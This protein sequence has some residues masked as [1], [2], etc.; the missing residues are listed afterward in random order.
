MDEVKGETTKRHFLVVAAS[1]RGAR[2]F[3]KKALQQGHAVTAICRAEDE[4]AALARMAG[5]LVEAT[6]TEGG[7]APSET[8]SQAKGCQQQHYEG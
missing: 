6:L 7:V 2:F 3:V 4:A 1:S 5:L 8:P